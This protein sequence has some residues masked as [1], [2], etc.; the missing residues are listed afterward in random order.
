MNQR[1][2]LGLA[3]G[4]VSMAAGWFALQRFL[5]DHSTIGAAVG[6]VVF[7]VLWTFLQWW[8]RARP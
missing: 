5:F 3:L 6:A 1:A 4:T 2:R 8:L 7:A